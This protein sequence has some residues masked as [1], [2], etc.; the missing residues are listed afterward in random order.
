MKVVLKAEICEDAGEKI[1][2]T[3]ISSLMSR[4]RGKRVIAVKVFTVYKGEFI[5]VFKEN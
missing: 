1:Y 5:M 3:P 4:S 2:G